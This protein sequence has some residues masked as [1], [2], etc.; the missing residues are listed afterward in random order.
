M[1]HNE[2]A[3]RVLALTY[4]VIALLIAIIV[5]SSLW[6]TLFRELID[7]LIPVIKDQPWR[8]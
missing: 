7:A 3:G 2:V 6:E 5:I 4:A 8:Y 1:N